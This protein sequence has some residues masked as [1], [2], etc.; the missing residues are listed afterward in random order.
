LA[1]TRKD[2]TKS[3]ALK[4]EYRIKKLPASKKISTLIQKETYWTKTG[5]Q[6]V[7][8]RLNN[9]HALLLFFKIFSVHIN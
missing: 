2:L 3:E 7:R 5:T 9:Y 1:A 4:L 6:N 8:E